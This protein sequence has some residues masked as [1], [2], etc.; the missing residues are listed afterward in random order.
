MARARTQTAINIFEMFVTDRALRETED[1]Y[2]SNTLRN[3]F[4]S[5]TVSGFFVVYVY[6]GPDAGALSIKL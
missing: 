6:V 1:C 5:I 2:I 4:I 3:L